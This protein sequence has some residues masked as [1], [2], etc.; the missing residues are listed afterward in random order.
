[1]LFRSLGG[2][3]TAPGYIGKDNAAGKSRKRNG[4]AEKHETGRVGCVLLPV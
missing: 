4:R 3:P 1:M 2:F